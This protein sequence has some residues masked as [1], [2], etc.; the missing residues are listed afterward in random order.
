M[1]RAP[2][3]SPRPRERMSLEERREQLLSCGRALFLE[4]TYDQVSMD[5]LATRAGVSKGLVFHYFSTKREL[6]VEVVRAAANE[7]LQ[8]MLVEDEGDPVSRLT[9]GLE[10]YLDYV[11]QNAQGYIALMTGG[12]GVDPELTAVVNQV[13]ATLAE[14]M[15]MGLP[16]QAPPGASVLV[17]GFLGLV[18]AAS[19]EW[20]E[21]RS[22]ERKDLVDVFVRTLTALFGPR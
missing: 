19:L 1:A 22:V 10:R 13:R 5:D 11:E 21:R 9:R 2:R 20:I 17:R 7:L 16:F 6:Y 18:E 3:R 4:K 8:A 15:L 12:V 14:R